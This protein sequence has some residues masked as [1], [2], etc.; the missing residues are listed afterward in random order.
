VIYYATYSKQFNTGV[1]GLD[2]EKEWQRESVPVED[3]PEWQ[4]FIHSIIL[5]LSSNNNFSKSV[6]F[7]AFSLKVM[8]MSIT[9]LKQDSAFFLSSRIENKQAWFY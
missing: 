9:R 7:F 6:S 1:R 2:P 8:P 3:C 4:F 5:K